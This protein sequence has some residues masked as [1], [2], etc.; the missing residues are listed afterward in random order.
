MLQSFQ[1]RKREKRYWLTKLSKSQIK[2]AIAFLIVALVSS[3]MTY[4][5]AQSAASKN[6]YLDD[7]PASATY[8]IKTD[9]TNYWAVRYDGLIPWSSTNAS[10][11]VNTAMDT[12]LALGD[13]GG[14]ITIVGSPSPI[15]ATLG[16]CAN[17]THLN[18]VGEVQITSTNAGADE[19]IMREGSLLTN[20]F[21]S[22]FGI[23]VV[24]YE[25]WTSYYALMQ[26]WTDFPSNGG[27]LEN[28]PGTTSPTYEIIDGVMSTEGVGEI[29]APYY[30]FWP[31]ES[32]PDNVTFA[33]AP[34]IYGELLIYELATNN[35]YHVYG[36]A[37]ITGAVNSVTVT[38]PHGYTLAG[39]AAEIACINITPQQSGSGDFWAAAWTNTTLTIGF[40]NQPNAS[41]WYFYYEVYMGIV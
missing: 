40:Q 5:Y 28:Y 18:G 6:I 19:F 1:F 23:G 16:Y 30:R 32:N 12:L 3:S 38:Y 34:S 41:T 27:V 35:Q 13:I 24:K 29:I 17:N 21:I 11:V 8:T 31:T 7:L 10:Y 33:I 9:G 20:C 26:K 37:S 36:P 22:Q 39:T 15:A 2:L 25:R 4:V 14:S